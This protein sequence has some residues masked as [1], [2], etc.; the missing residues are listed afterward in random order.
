MTR[1][2]TPPEAPPSIRASGSSPYFFT[3]S[4]EANYQRILLPI[5]LEVK[6]PGS[7]GSLW[8][9]DLWLRNHGTETVPIAPWPCPADEV[10]PAVF[11]LTKTLAPNE[12]LHNLTPFF[13]L[14]PAIPGRVIFLGR[15]G[16]ADVD[17]QL[18]ISDISRNVLD[19]GTELPVVRDEELKTSTAH[20]LNV[21][22]DAAFRLTLRV[23]DVTPS[24]ASFVVRV[25]EMREGVDASVLLVTNVVATS[26]ETGEFRD[27]PSYGEIGDLSAQLPAGTAPRALRIEVEP[28]TAGSRFWT[29]V[30]I[31]N[32][33]TQHVT[34]V[35][36]Q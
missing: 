12:S 33:A 32:N 19:A 7:N 6:T 5:Y 10:C 29:F 23:Y 2:A 14:P 30:S 18:R 1:G 20:L 8:Q 27:L 16:A 31:T 34:L 4:S 17:V 28:K 11:P 22:L 21:P 13:R 36:P 15:N 25:Y 24:P 3:A 26:P 35:T 9:T